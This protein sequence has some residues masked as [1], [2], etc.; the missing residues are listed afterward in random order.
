MDKDREKAWALLKQYNESD[1]LL[2]HALAVESIMRHFAKIKKEDPEFWGNV[3]LLHDLDWEKY[4]EEHCRKSSEILKQE[5]YSDKL[6]RAIESH[7]WNIVTDVEPQHDMEKVLYAIDELSGLITATAL[8]RP[9]KD[10]REVQLKSVKK[11]WKTPAFSAGVDR[12]IIQKGCDMMGMELDQVIKESLEAMKSIAPE[13]G[14][15]G[16]S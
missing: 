3:G 2:K 8:V 4:P 7:G 6:I 13:L 1:S 10:I 14:L 11:K 12:S 15:A 9:S 5:G 16:E